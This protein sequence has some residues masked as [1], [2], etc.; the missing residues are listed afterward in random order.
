MLEGYF[1]IFRED[2]LQNIDYLLQ[3]PAHPRPA[4]LSI[5]N[6]GPVPYT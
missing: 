5:D 6:Y 1:V 2:K 3:N 4:Y